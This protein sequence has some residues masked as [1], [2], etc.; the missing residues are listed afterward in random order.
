[1][2]ENPNLVSCSCGNVMEVVQGKVDLNAR[3]D[4]NKPIT[5]EAAECMAK[6]R[7]RCPMNSC[8]KIFCTNPQCS[9]EPYHNGKTCQQHKEFKEMKKCRYCLSK[10][11][12]PSP[13]MLPAFKEVCRSADCINLMNNSC[14][15]VL[16]CGHFCC[17]FR[18]E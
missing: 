1:M 17:G 14:E 16:A 4:N 5:K 11:T 3:D 13:S 10:L 2:A 9:A 18:G 7:V 12:Q 6:Y 8:G 15:K